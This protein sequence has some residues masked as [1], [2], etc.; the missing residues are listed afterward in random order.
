MIGFFLGNYNFAGIK[1]GIKWFQAAADPRRAGG[2]GALPGGRWLGADQAWAADLAVIDG[3]PRSRHAGR[4]EARVSAV[5]RR[6]GPDPPG[7]IRGR[8]ER[9]S[10]SLGGV[11]RTPPDV[12]Y[13]YI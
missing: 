10:G 1:Y 8:D 6:G 9:R 7:R 13:I 12:I 11:M 5:R 2:P 4:R 3:C